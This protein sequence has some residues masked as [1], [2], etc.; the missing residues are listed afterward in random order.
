M[1]SYRAGELVDEFKVRNEDEALV[2][3]IGGPLLRSALGIAMLV[4]T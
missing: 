3:R 2:K 4:F 1:A